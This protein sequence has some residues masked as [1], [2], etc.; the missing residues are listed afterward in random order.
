[1]A[2]YMS[3][4]W[5][6][7]TAMTFKPSDKKVEFS[8]GPVDR[9]VEID[10]QNCAKIEFWEGQGTRGTD[11][12]MGTAGSGRVSLPK[13]VQVRVRSGSVVLGRGASGA[14][15]MSASASV[16]SSAY[17]PRA[18]P[19]TQV[20]YA[21]SSAPSAYR[22]TV[23]TSR[24][25]SPPSSRAGFSSAGNDWQTQELP[26]DQWINGVTGIERFSDNNNSRQGE[27][28]DD[29]DFDRRTLGP[30]DSVSQIGYQRR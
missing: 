21:G 26:R 12:L 10:F 2:T 25:P 14:S 29:E 11:F 24:Q 13:G 22:S 6:D 1:M 23:T 7:E 9:P 17:A 30:Q 18:P 15:E 19:P 8:F 5:S 3:R 4:Y 16:V 27:S 20:S 28:D